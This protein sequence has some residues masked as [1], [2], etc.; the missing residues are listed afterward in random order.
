MLGG[1]MR[2]AGVLAA[3]GLIALEKMPA[4]LG[5]D[6]E[7]AKLLATLLKKIPQLDVEEKRVLTNILVVGIARTGFDSAEI[8]H[9]LKKLGV[10]V[11]ALDHSKLRIVTHRDVNQEQILHAAANIK[12]LVDQMSG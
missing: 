11:S 3:A 9:R 12:Q 2:Q 7:N 4:R 6:H 10:L 8:I 5:E 1:G